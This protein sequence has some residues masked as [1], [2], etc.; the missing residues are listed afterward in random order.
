[1]RKLYEV[2]QESK[3]L[4]KEIKKMEDLYEST[5]SMLR[6][7]YIW[8]DNEV[9]ARRLLDS[10]E[11]P[12]GCWRKLLNTNFKYQ[13]GLNKNK[14]LI[15]D[16]FKKY[17]LPRDRGKLAYELE[18][19]V[20]NSIEEYI[21]YLKKRKKYVDFEF[22]ERYKEFAQKKAG[23]YEALLEQDD[24]KML[25]SEFLLSWVKKIVVKLRRRPKIG[26]LLLN[27]S[28][29]ICIMLKLVKEEEK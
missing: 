24:M 1:M 8:E 20:E 10:Y 12:E 13:Y 14:E 28:K 25:L 11:N 5:K 6:P 21:K 18:I 26:V 2:L 29:I 17:Y 7:P 4:K 23:K 16:A 19:N 3:E 27:F 22:E 9:I 15:K